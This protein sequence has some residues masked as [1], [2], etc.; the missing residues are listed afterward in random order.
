MESQGAWRRD[1]GLICGASEAELEADRADTADYSTNETVFRGSAGLSRSTET[2]Q[3]TA[4]D[5]QALHKLR[6]TWTRMQKWSPK[7]TVAI[8]AQRSP[9]FPLDLHPCG[10]LLVDRL[11]N[12]LYQTNL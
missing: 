10:G 8:Y 5:R 3:Q 9:L 11:Q 6:G 12:G 1:D 2:I 4:N 7:M